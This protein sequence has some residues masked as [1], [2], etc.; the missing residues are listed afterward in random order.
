MNPLEIAAVLDEMSQGRTEAFHHI[1]KAYSLPLR[2]FMAAHV[3]HMDDAD[4]LAQETFLAALKDISRFRRGDDFWTW[5]RGI[6][7]HKLLDHF[8]RARRRN[9]ALARFR[10]RV[11]EEVGRELDAEAAGD[12]HETIE[13]LLACIARLPER[14][15][16]VV[17]AG[18]EGDR[19]ARLAETLGTS[20]GSVY[21][22]HYR[23][24][25]LLRECVQREAP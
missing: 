23:A 4:D 12:R 2:S 11:V 5:L 24:A 19:P 6:A 13:A 7:R 21:T 16:L 8:R 17:R 15:R 20:V 22:L 25:K 14:M 1:V 10:E 9:D 3:Y 18:L